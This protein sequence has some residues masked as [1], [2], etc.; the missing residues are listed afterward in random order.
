M[1]EEEIL[2]R[3]IAKKCLVISI[4]LIKWFMHHIIVQS[5]HIECY[6]YSFINKTGT[7]MWYT[8][9]IEKKKYSKFIENAIDIWQVFVY[10]S[11]CISKDG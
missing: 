2:F 8:V 3:I 9:R 5:F 10:A 1:Y 6:N 4:Y 11:V 7:Y